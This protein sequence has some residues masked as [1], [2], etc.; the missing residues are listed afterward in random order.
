MNFSFWSLVFW[1]KFCGS[2]FVLWS[3]FLLAIVLSVLL[4]LTTSDYTF[5]IFKL[6]L[7]SSPVLLIGY[8]L[9][10][11]YFSVLCFV[12]HVCLFVLLLAI[13]LCAL[14]RFTSSYYYFSILKPLVDA[15]WL[16][17][18]QR[19]LNYL[20]FQSYVICVL[21]PTQLTKGTTLRV[22]C[23]RQEQL[24]LRGCLC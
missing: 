22:S 1:V 16:S 3:L 5:G 6:F 15:F 4:W 8:V 23:G 10:N 18:S 2:L 13:L 12:D 9:F 19:P 14:P 17:C 21:C 20:A 24:S 11:L 7:I